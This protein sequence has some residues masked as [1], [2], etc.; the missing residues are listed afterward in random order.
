MPGTG[1]K[2][3]RAT[4]KG[5]AKLWKHGWALKLT[6]LPM[7]PLHTPLGSQLLLPV[8]CCLPSTPHLGSPGSFS[9]IT[10][11]GK[12]ECGPMGLLTNLGAPWL[13]WL[14][15]WGS[16]VPGHGFLLWHPQPRLPQPL[17]PG[18]ARLQQEGTATGCLALPKAGRGGLTPQPGT[19]HPN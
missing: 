17:R 12:Q 9:A 11:V 14:L 13:V 1:R 16:Q 7:F 3:R 18:W 8:G 6:I 15:L 19:P 2:N 5:A 10:G 4:W